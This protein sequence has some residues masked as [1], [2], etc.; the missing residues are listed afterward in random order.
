MCVIFNFFCLNGSTVPLSISAFDFNHR[1]SAMMLLTG[2]FLNAPD[3]DGL[4]GTAVGSHA[5]VCLR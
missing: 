1:V 3:R 5:F 2:N 4:H